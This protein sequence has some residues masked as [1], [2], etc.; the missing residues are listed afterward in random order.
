MTKPPR[1]FVFL[2]IAIGLHT[3][4]DWDIPGTGLA[5]SITE[6]LIV[7]VIGWFLIFVMIDAGL[8]EV[9][10]L[11]GQLIVKKKKRGGH[12]VG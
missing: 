5:T 1:F 6:E 11:Q 10:T 4:W 12:K 7:V 3:L 2:L 8:R 9:R